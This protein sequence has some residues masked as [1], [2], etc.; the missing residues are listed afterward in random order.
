MTPAD[1]QAAARKY[2]VDAGLVQTTLSKD[3]LPSAIETL[4]ALASLKPAPA[5]AAEPAAAP[6]AAPA[7]AASGPVA[8]L[9]PLVLRS[10]LPQ[11]DVKLLFTVGVG[12]RP[13]RQGGPGRPSPP[14]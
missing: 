8:E 9:K 12:P 3:P 10:K 2:F 11:L 5:G 6:A 13:R 7:P 14:R 1:L 4:P